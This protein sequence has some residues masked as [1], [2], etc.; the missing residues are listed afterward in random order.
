[1]RPVLSTGSIAL[2]IA[3]TI[4]GWPRGH[5][6]ELIGDATTGKTTLSLLACRSAQRI[7]AA[8]ALLDADHT[9]DP[10][11]AYALGL[12]RRGLVV[13]EPETGEEALAVAYR[14]LRTGE[15]ACLVIDAVPSLLPAAVREKPVGAVD[16]LA[17]RRML[18]AG[19]KELARLAPRFEAVVLLVNRPAMRPG[20]LGG[21]VE[22]SVGGR[23]L[24]ETAALRVRLTSTSMRADAMRVRA[25][26]EK[27]DLAGPAATDLVLRWG[28]GVDGSTDLL[29]GAFD[30]GLITVDHHR[31]LYLGR[32]CLGRFEQA[33]AAMV[34]E[35]GR[36]VAD[37]V[38]A[39]LPWQD[40][41]EPATPL[42]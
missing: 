13:A 5:L 16:G 30:L 11:Y 3:T 31:Q 8:A 24:R 12:E 40:G 21:W 15:V 22:D 35:L 19:V 32:V 29:A 2:D 25:T 37:A 7:G 18:G 23:R 39:R 17:Q 27:N 36:R 41:P 4:G 28:S 20:E 10:V 33:R 34:G 42:A 26:V 14:L 6:I 9:F 1:M 38:A